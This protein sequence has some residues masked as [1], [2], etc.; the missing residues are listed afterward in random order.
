MTAVG[1]HSDLLR[2]SEHYRYVISSLEEA[3]REA[4]TGAIPVIRSTDDG[5]PDA[6]ASNDRSDAR[7][8]KETPR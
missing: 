1:T 8:Q 2:E 3:E 6:A 5:T 7:T 4:R